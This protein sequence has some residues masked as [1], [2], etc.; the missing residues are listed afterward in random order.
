[1]TDIVDLGPEPEDFRTA[2]LEGLSGGQKSIP[3]KFLYDERGSELF[4]RICELDEYYPTRT[5]LGIMDAHI[6]EMAEAIGPWARLVEFGAGS[7][8]KTKLLLSALESPAVYSPI[9]ISKSALRG[10]AETMRTAF[11][12]LEIIPVCADY[13][14]PMVLPDPEGDVEKT[15]AYFPGSTIG[16]FEPDAAVDFLGRI[17]DL[18]GDGGGLL[19][20]VDRFKSAEIIEPAYNDSEGVTRQFTSNLLRRA[21]REAGADFDLDQFE[22]RAVFNE[23]AGRVEIYQVSQRDQTVHVGERRFDFEAGEGI[24]TEHSYKYTPARFRGIAVAA[25]FEV[26]EVWTDADDWFSVWYLSVG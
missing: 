8:V 26:A 10:C 15:V 4:E 6:A 7:G 5:E 20:G 21:N 25:G 22:H 9:E 24:L 2:L 23:E 19:I 16:N 1:M 3:C 13:T 17:A 18:C 12:D 14:E 11:P